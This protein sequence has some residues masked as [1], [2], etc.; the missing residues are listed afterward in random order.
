MANRRF[1]PLFLTQFL[2]AFNDNLF[3]NALVMVIAYK[4]SHEAA[5]AQLLVTMA[6]ALFMLPYFLFSATA[7]QIADSYD[8]A[9]LSRVTKLFEI[10]IMAVAAIGFYIGNMEFLLFVLFCLGVQSTFFGPIKYALLPQ[11]LRDDELVTGNAFIEAG[12]F[13][14]ILLGTIAGGVLVMREQGEAMISVAALI[15][16]LGGYMTSRFIPAAAA[17]MP[18]LK[19]KWNIVSQTWNMVKHDRKNKRVFNCIIGISWFWLVGAT[20]LSQ[21]PVF[22][23]ELLEADE[24][25]VTL[26][27]TVFSVGIGVGSFL[28]S[29]LVDGK[30]NSKFVPYAAFGMS[31]FMADLFWVSSSMPLHLHEYLIGVSEF[32]R[33]WA[34]IRVLFDLFMLALCGGIY[35]VPLYAI[36]QHDSDP[37]YRARTIATNNVI[38]ALFMV[39]SAVIVV[40]LMQTGLSLAG[41]WLVMALSNGVVAVFVRKITLSSRASRGIRD[42]TKD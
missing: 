32:V 36:M 31:V 39:V 9:K 29:W 34:N 10:I 25:V 14:A 41:L 17:P 18:G 37:A 38:N 16:A 19:V 28:S 11:H 4:S 30:I 7:G 12:T 21:F 13:L 42:T 8:R 35:I 26:L 6:A 1:L 33:S 3:K 27:L 24:T 22:A 40:L 5:H 23:K 15:V 20:F 2:G